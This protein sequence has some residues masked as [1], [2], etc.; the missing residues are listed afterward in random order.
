[1]N[2]TVNMYAHTINHKFVK[3]LFIDGRPSL[4]DT[5]VSANGLH[6]LW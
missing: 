4:T 6:L 1:M 3:N 5:D 2:E